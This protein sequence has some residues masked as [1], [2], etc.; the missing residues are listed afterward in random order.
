[1][2]TGYFNLCTLKLTHFK[3]KLKLWLAD[4]AESEVVGTGAGLILERHNLDLLSHDIECRICL[5][6]LLIYQ[7]KNYKGGVSEEKAVNCLSET[8]EFRTMRL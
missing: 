2:I 6:K 5:Q 7:K 8:S 1:M 3:I 4:K